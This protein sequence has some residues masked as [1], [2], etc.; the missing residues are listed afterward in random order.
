LSKSNDRKP[1]VEKEKMG[2]SGRQHSEGVRMGTCPYRN[3]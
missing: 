3:L 1:I 2:E